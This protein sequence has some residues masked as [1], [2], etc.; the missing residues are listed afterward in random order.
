MAAPQQQAMGGADLP[1][2]LNPLTQVYI[3]ETINLL[4]T[5][6]CGCCNQRSKYWGYRSKEDSKLR[7][8]TAKEIEAG[9]TEFPRRESKA[10]FY[11][12][13]DSGC[14]ERACCCG[15]HGFVLRFYDPATQQ[16]TNV[17]ER[18]GCFSGKCCLFCCSCSDICIEEFRMYKPGAQGQAGSVQGDLIYS[19]KQSNCCSQPC[20]VSLL[21]Q[22]SGEAEP[23]MKIATPCFFGGCKSLC[24]GD[25]FPITDQKG[26]VGHLTKPPPPDC[27][28]CIK[29]I[30]TDA[31]DYFITY[32]ADSTPDQKLAM[33]SGAFMADYM[34]FA[35]DNGPIYCE[36]CYN[37]DIACTICNCYICGVIRPCTIRS[38]N[39]RQNVFCFLCK[40]C[41]PC[42][43]L[44]GCSQSITGL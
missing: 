26:N 35:H 33:L 34:L 9:N 38:K 2:V 21:V 11:A 28:A 8:A 37:C 29:E 5:A 7:Y 10:V 20:G 25:E 1:T 43:I 39:Y 14:F 30:C 42:H 19:A 12:E 3:G 16:P 4:E 23:S 15:N 18:P 36:S 13:E 6:T 17:L 32:A 41:V 31:D 22:G 24:I 44:P 27:G 40:P